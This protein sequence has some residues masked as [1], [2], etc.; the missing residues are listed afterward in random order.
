M[1]AKALDSDSADPKIWNNIAIARMELGKYEEALADAK[2]AIQIDEAY[3]NGYLR[4]VEA[5]M[6]LHRLEVINE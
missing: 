2:Q 3:L 6:F 4:A 1:Y 5:L